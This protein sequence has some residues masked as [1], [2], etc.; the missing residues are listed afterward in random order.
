MGRFVLVLAVLTV[1]SCSTHLT[2]LDTRAIANQVNACRSIPTY[3][4]GGPAAMLANDCVCNAKG[5]LARAGQPV[6]AGMENCP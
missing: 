3:I 4:D 1:V 2:T 6:E 5:I